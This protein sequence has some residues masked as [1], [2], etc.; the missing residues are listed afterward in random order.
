MKKQRWFQM[1]LVSFRVRQFRSVE[2]SGWINISDVTAFIG[3]NE[4]GKTNLLVPLWKLN[5]AKDGEINAIQ[6]Y[7][8]DEYHIIRALKRKP[9]FIE[10]KFHLSDRANDKI[11]ELTGLPKVQIEYVI[12]KRDFAG[13]YYVE[14]PEAKGPIEPE[15]NFIRE[16]ITKTIKDIQGVSSTIKADESLK[17]NILNVLDSS[18]VELE[19]IKESTISLQQMSRIKENFQGVDLSKAAKRSI[20]PPRFGQ[21]MDEI[22]GHI[23]SLDIP[24]LE[25]NMEANQYIVERL[26]SFVYYSN[27]GNLDSEIYLPHV[28]QN[29]DRADLGVKEAAKARTLKVLFNFVKLKPQEILELGEDFPQGTSPSQEQIEI[30]AEKKK[31]RDV[32]L[33]SASTQLTSRFR[34]WWK[35]GDYRFRFQADGNH[36]R[37]WVSDDKRPEDIE[38]EARSTGLQ[39]FLSFYLVFLV[40]SQSS[41]EGSILLL[42]E[43]GNSLHPIAQRDLSA[44]FDNLSK[45]NQILYTTHSPFMVDPNHLDRVKAVN[46]DSAGSTAVSANLRAG[47]GQTKQTQSIYPVHAALGLSVSDTLLQG[48]LSV[49]VEGPSDQHYLSAIKN[50][51]ISKGLILPNREIVFIPA[52]GVKGIAAVVSIITG[53]D[54]AL[55]FV[56]LDGDGPGLSSARKLRDSIFESSPDH[57]V[58]VSEVIGLVGAEIEDLFSVDFLADIVTRMLPRPADLEE[59]FSDIVQPGIPIVSQIETYA[60]SNGIELQKGWKVELA[61]RTKIQLLKGRAAKSIADDCLEVWTNLF[62]SLLQ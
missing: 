48:C 19:D 22:D 1:K 41:H 24:E 52:G 30:V 28:I 50:V 53:K 40:E 51:L 20:I 14:F 38:L 37:I 17:D 2:D 25:E 26:P 18:L 34:E 62:E 13:D 6:D 44:F 27:Y 36:F 59:D 8:R 11:S 54:Q 61:Q 16:L 31:E 60:S 39:W 12:V 35:Q 43:P 49:I 9:I 55:P 33:Q 10:A 7:P 45:T 29:M 23:E 47:E 57:V 46:I 32:L 4:S 15:V 3:T 56:L 21:L 5:P 58:L 42:D